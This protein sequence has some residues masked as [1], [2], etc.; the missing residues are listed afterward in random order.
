VNHGHI[1]RLDSQYFQ[2]G[3]RWSLQLEATAL[4]GQRRVQVVAVEKDG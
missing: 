2:K 1:A 3:S 4:D